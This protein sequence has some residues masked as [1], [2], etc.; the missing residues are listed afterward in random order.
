MALRLLQPS[1]PYE[2]QLQGEADDAER[3]SKWALGIGLASFVYTGLKQQPAPVTV[4]QQSTGSSGALTPSATV[5]EVSDVTGV[6]GASADYSRGDHAHAHGVRG[7][8]TGLGVGLHSLA[9]STTPG[10]ESAA[11]WQLLN[12]TRAAHLVFIGPAS[13][14]AL[15]PTW[16]ALTFADLP[17]SMN[18]QFSGAGNAMGGTT[19]ATP[20]T[21]IGDYVWG[22][23]AYVTATGAA[24]MPPLVPGTDFGATVGAD[25][26]ITQLSAGLDLYTMIFHVQRAS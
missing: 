18:L 25:N 7:A 19:I 15:A 23:T 24:V 6:A 22:V 2:L 12:N 14:G 11:N 20:G 21:V 26:T 4:V 3:L 9:T 16:R 17:P 1:T 10:F 8:I 5:T 13:G